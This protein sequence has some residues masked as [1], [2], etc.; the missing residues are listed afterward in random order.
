[1]T[2]DAELTFAIDM[3]RA[4]GDIMKQYYRADRQIEVKDD[5]SP[6]TVADKAINDLLIERV[7]VAFPQTGVLGEEASWESDRKQLWVCDPIDG[8]IAYIIRVPT[9][10]FSLALVDDGVPVVAAAYNPWTDEL[11]TATKDGGSYRHDQKLQVSSRTWGKGINIA[12]SNGGVF[13]PPHIRQR[14]RDE[15]VYVNQV[16]GGVARGC[17]IAEGS[18][19]GHLFSYHGAH[20]MAAI[21]LLIEEAGG[22]VTDLD[23]NEQRYDRPLNGAA[24]SNGLIHDK[25]LSIVEDWRAH[26]RD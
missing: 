2:Y 7:K 5:D 19:E 4:A 21:K 17:M 18:I 1:M 12:S 11:Y 16:I 10:M 15:G 14:L 23:G 26:T 6:V 13:D 8:T 3:A 24:L 9:S 20:D 25:L 22:R